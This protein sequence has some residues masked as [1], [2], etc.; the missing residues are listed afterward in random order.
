M[1]VHRETIEKEQHKIESEG[2]RVCSKFSLVHTHAHTHKNTEMLKFGVNVHS[3][4]IAG[5]L[6]HFYC[7]KR[8]HLFGLLNSIPPVNIRVF[9]APT[10]FHLFLRLQHLTL[11]L[12][13]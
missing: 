12:A 3:A 2:S 7:L 9:T 6:L 13:K 1:S 10:A 5:K 11:P 8:S 4:I